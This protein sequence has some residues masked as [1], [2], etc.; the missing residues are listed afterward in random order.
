MQSILHTVLHTIEH[1]FHL[2]YAVLGALFA[3][4]I[5]Y[6]QD[7]LFVSM[8]HPYHGLFHVDASIPEHRAVCVP[9]VMG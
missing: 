9:Q 1:Y 4:M 5:V 7:H 6:A 8:P 2:F 3:H